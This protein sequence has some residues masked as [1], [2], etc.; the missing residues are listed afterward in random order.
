MKKLFLFISAMLIFQTCCFGVTAQVQKTEPSQEIR[1]LIVFSQNGKFGLK[2]KQGQILIQPIYKKLIRA[3]EYSWI[4]Q[5]KIRFGLVDNYGKVLVKLNY[6]H[7][8]RYFGHFSKFGNEKDYGL[9]DEKGNILIPP[10]YSSIDPL[11]GGNFLTCKKYKYG[12]IS[13]KGKVL[14]EN[15][16]DY[17]YMPEPTVMRIEYEGRWYEI[18]KMEKNEITLPEGVQKLTYNNT[19]FKITDLVV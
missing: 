14:I 12:V 9:Y 2:N 3:G 13:N 1:G 11:F 16:F 15:K 4:V 17:I 19:D 10:E 6:R 7:V 8:D 18:E 5:E